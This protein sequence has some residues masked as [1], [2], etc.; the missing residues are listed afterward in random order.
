[1]EKEQTAVDFFATRAI[2]L[3]EQ[4]Y[5]GKLDGIEFNRYMTSITKISK[6][7][8]EQQ[9]KEARLSAPE[10]GVLKSSNYSIETDFYFKRK[11]IL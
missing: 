3:F 5:Q 9:I 2:D 1:M 10:Y 7:M 4:Y 11:F 6:A 8:F